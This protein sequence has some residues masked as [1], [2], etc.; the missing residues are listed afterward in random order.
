MCVDLYYFLLHYESEEVRKLSFV[1]LTPPHILILKQILPP[2][3]P[4]LDTDP[5]WNKAMMSNSVTFSLNISKKNI[6]NYL[7]NEKDVVKHCVYRHT[8]SSHI[9]SDSA[10]HSVCRYVCCWAILFQP[11]NKLNKYCTACLVSQK[12]NVNTL[13][14]LVYLFSPF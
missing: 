10:N 3:I 5:K 6:F 12:L 11:V 9:K 2:H 13:P 8:I 1:H 4:F 7:I 14:S